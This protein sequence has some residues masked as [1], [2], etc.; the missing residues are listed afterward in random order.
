MITLENLNPKRVPLTPEMQANQERLHSA[1]VHVEAHVGHPLVVT[2]GVRSLDDHK[3]IYADLARKRKTHLIRIP[4][5][6]K[7]LNGAAVD[8]YDPDGKL[9]AWC[10]A[11]ESVLETLGLWVEEKDD[12]RRVHFQVQPYGSWMPGKTRFFRP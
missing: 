1:M 3:R 8:V 6:S 10:K 9:H 11:N 12:Q 2:S 7:H 5:Q 4:M